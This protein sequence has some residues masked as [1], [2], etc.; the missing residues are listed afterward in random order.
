[1]KQGPFA[2]RRLCCPDGSGA[3]TGPSADPPGRH[4]TSR[5]ITAY[6]RPSLPTPRVAEH[7]AGEG[8]PSSRTDLPAVPLPLPREVHHRCASRLFAA[9]MAF[10]VNSPARLLLVPAN[11]ASVTRRQ[12]SHHVTDRPVASPNGAFDTGLRRRAFPPDAASLLPGALAPTG[13]GLPPAGRCELMFRSG[14]NQA[15]PPNAGHTD[16]SASGLRTERV[17]L[18]RAPRRRVQAPVAVA[19]LIAS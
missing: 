16:S 4:A 9:S 19:W 14:H 1:M 11:G 2:H 17:P 13:T 18:T 6:T 8:F 10:A 12:D 15:P 7:G 5:L 3:T